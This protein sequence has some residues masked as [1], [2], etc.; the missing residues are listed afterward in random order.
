MT[1]RYLVIDFESYYS[2]E[3]SLRKMTPPEYI[4]NPQFRSHGASIIVG[5]SGQPTYLEHEQLVRLFARLAASDKPI[6]VVSHNALFDMCVLAWVYGYI[7]KLMIDTMGMSRTLLGHI[8]RSHS[9]DSVAQ[10]LGLPA[11]GKFLSNVM[12]LP[13]EEIKARGWWPDYTGYAN[14][15]A[16]LCRGIFQILRKTFPPSE[17]GVMHDVINCAV[18][19][20]FVLDR[21]VLAQHLFNVE[22]EKEQL[23]VNCGM[24]SRDELMSNDKFAEALRRLGVE[25]ELKVSL[26][27]NKETYA[28]AKTD[29]FMVALDEHPDSQVQALVAAR[30]GHKSTL[31][32]SRTKRFIAISQ[33]DASA[34]APGKYPALSFPVPLRY[35]AAHTHRLGGD[36]KL[37]A[38][39][40]PRDF[41]RN[42]I[43]LPGRLRTSLAA[44]K[45]Y[46]VFTCDASQIEA[47]I[48][49]AI[50]GE[51]DLVDGFRRGDDIYSEFSGSEVYH[52]K[53]TKAD[54]K[55]RFVGKQCILGLG[56]QMG[57]AKFINTVRVQSRLNLGA[58][59]I[60]DPIE[61]ERIV[62]AYRR[63][64][65]NISSSWGK[66]R[67]MI[68]QLAACDSGLEFG[69]VRLGHQEITG[70]GGLK[71]Y[72][73]GLKRE[74]LDGQWKWMFTYGGK[75]KQLYGGIV[76]ENIVQFLARIHIMEA[77]QR[78]KRITSIPMAMQVHD[79]LIYVIPE[80]IVDQFRPIV[81]QEM[82]RPP[83]WMP[84]IPLDA[85]AGVGDNYGEAK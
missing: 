52:K 26:K 23:L 70:P 40:M 3:Y 2:A 66:L 43:K 6:A 7:P 84:D 12:G 75:P 8:L 34:A 25:P 1:D 28:F 76:L 21:T 68:P 83:I 77:E 58:E 85:E 39:N 31:E 81:L 16:W 47:R 49:A 65:K 24:T 32:E 17:Y 35:G 55:E 14:H 82:R 51:T 60:I 5:D 36:W 50:N 11:K 62:T 37:N 10:H 22:Q 41:T 46:K 44:P 72:Y 61:A 27:T 38:Q 73:H 45:G 20:R 80:G 79:E 67:D 71:L 42:G 48:N 74:L 64:F 33:I 63:K 56:Y 15:D 59:L 13:L 18:S 54:K 69:P 30:V 9:L 78:I 57:W 53:V 4:L 29:A 19:P